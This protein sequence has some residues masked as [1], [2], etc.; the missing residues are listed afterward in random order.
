MWAVRPSHRAGCKQSLHSV[1]CRSRLNL[2]V[3]LRE[4]KHWW[5]E[6]AVQLILQSTNLQVTWHTYVLECNWNRQLFVLSQIELLGLQELFFFTEWISWFCQ[7]WSLKI[8]RPESRN[9]TTVEYLTLSGR[10]H[11]TWNTTTLCIQRSQMDRYWA[12]AEQSVNMRSQT[13]TK[14]FWLPSF[15]IMVRV[16]QTKVNLVFR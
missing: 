12:L 9:K 1:D 5:T 8:D 13:I 15:A 4:V 11:G 6:P 16:I 3:C 7:T 10:Q 14:V 2:E